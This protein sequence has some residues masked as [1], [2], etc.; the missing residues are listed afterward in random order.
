MRAT[1]TRTARHGLA[2]LVQVMAR[3]V[4]R[5]IRVAE[6]LWN[7]AIALVVMSA[8]SNSL[9][10]VFSSLLLAIGATRHRTKVECING[11]KED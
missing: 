9:L 5:D 8:T 3:R 2:L 6:W 7:V 4:R 11:I 10:F 1:R